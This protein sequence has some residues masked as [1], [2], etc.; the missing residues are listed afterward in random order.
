MSTPVVTSRSR[1][2]P[3]PIDH[4]ENQQHGAC[5]GQRGGSRQRVCGRQGG[6]VGHKPRKQ[7]RSHGHDAAK[8]RVPEQYPEFRPAC[9][10]EKDSRR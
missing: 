6:A 7:Q 9:G 3:K 1:A 10:G 2:T 4:D 8:H 5:R